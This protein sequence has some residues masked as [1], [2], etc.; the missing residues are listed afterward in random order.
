MPSASNRHQ[1][2]EAVVAGVRCWITFEVLGSVTLSCLVALERSNERT[3][4]QEIER[5]SERSSERSNDRASDRASARAIERTNER[6][7]CR[8]CL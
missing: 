3:I 1:S 2:Q 5:S 6:S 7:H 4:E 8:T